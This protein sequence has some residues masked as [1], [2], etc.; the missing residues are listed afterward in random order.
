MSEFQFG[1]VVGFFGAFVLI[2]IGMAIIGWA[3]MVANKRAEGG[4]P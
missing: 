4:G 3:D 1:I 2:A